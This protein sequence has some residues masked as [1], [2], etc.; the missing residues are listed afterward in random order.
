MNDKK[1]Y[2]HIPQV[3]FLFITFLT[4]SLPIRSVPTFIELLIGAMLTQ[5]GF[6]TQAWLAVNMHRHWTSYYKWLQK[7]KW[8]WVKLGTQM[9]KL[10]IAFFP[11]QQWFLIIDDTIIYRNSKKAPGSKINHQHGSKANRPK[12]V[13]GQNWVSLASVVTKGLSTAAIPLLF[14]MMRLD[15]NTSKLDAAKVLLKTILP[16][17]A[18]EKTCLL[19]DSWYMR[20]TL[21]LYALEKGIHVI[22]QVRKD[23]ALYDIPE[24]TGKRGRPRKYGDKYTPERVARLSEKRECHFIYGKEQWV[25]YKS[26]IARARFLKGRPVR[27]VWVYFEDEHGVITNERLILATK[28]TLNPW[29]IISS[30]A[31][32]WN[33][34]TMF[35]Q[36]KNNWGW[37]EAWQQ[38]RQVLHRWTHILSI[39]Y[40]LPQL[41]ALI[42]GAQINKLSYLTPW[43]SN[44]SITAG[45]VRLWLKMILGHVRIRDWWNPKSRKFEPPCKPISHNKPYD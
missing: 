43:R 11:K 22:G 24:R 44:K 36:I 3:F 26:V 18:A 45:Q 29:K 4:I 7:G 20:G 19:I 35:A 31:K 28:I 17:F 5:A 21:I 25:H 15:G 39:G 10:L 8:S 12:Y 1:G 23:T 14:R 37:K 40:A 13:R 34:E 33:I 6:V 41:L 2:R 27:A 32:R 16:V 38:S 30:Y 42:G 9:A